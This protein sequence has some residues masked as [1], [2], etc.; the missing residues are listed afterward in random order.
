[1]A[2]YQLLSLCNGEQDMV[3][4]MWVAPHLKDSSDTC[5]R[6]TLIRMEGIRIRYLGELDLALGLLQPA[7]KNTM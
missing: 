1:M 4:W 3:G 5:L 7:G 2:L 6:E